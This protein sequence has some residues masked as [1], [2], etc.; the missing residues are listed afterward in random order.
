MERQPDCVRSERHGANHD[1]VGTYRNETIADR[2]HS[3]RRE[4]PRAFDKP[5]E[6]PDI[7][8]DHRVAFE[9]HRPD[10][11]RLSRARPKDLPHQLTVSI[12][13][14]DVAWA[15]DNRILSSGGVELRPRVP[16]QGRGL[17]EPEIKYRLQ[18]ARPAACKGAEVDSRLRARFQRRN[19]T[20]DENTKQLQAATA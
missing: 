2:R 4:P 9:I 7:H 12:E 11:P 20:P 15:R 13:E 3:S 10:H 1:R 14:T 18:I 8:E 19:Y 17:L 5:L 16:S 6:I